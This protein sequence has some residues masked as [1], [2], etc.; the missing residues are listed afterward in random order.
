MVA[1]SYIPS[2]PCS[3]G[4]P[5]PPGEGASP[6]PRTRSLLTPQRGC[7]S[8]ARDTQHEATIGP[9]ARVGLDATSHLGPFNELKD[10]DSMLKSKQVCVCC[11]AC[12]GL[13]RLLCIRA[14]C[15]RSAMLCCG[16]VGI[17]IADLDFKEMADPINLLELDFYT[18]TM[19]HH[20]KTSTQ[21]TLSSRS[22]KAN[23]LLAVLTP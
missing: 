17:R 4:L 14:L 6:R 18:S 2:G 19:V 12:C 13:E 9:Q 23:P 16:Q 10:T 21:R 15:S 22:A 7:H 11:S 5:P 3:S 20:P 8:A 1:H